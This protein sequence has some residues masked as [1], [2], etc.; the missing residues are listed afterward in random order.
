MNMENKTELL[1]MDI[2]DLE[3][4][5]L[6]QGQPRF[7]AKQI[8]GWIY[9]KEVSSFYEMSD[10]PKELRLRLDENATISIPRVLK[11]RVSKDNTRKFLLE[12][13]DKK[14]VETV[15][16][17]QGGDKNDRYS[18][19]IS[20]QV[21]CPVG[22]AFCATGASGF[23]RSL[24]A[25][26]MAGQVLGSRRELAKRLKIQDR[27]L[28]TN[29]VYMGMGEPMLNYDEVLKSVYMLNDHRGIDIGQRHITI[30]TAGEVKGIQ[31]LARE[32]I[33]ITLAVSLHACNNEL[34]SRLI[35]LNR[36]YPLELLM[37][38]VAE[39]IEISGRR[40]TFEYIMLDG[41]NMDLTDARAM[42]K[43]LKPL[44]ANVN[45]I[46]YNEVSGLEF[47]RPSPGQIR[48]FYNWLTE[49]GLNVTLREER[50]SDIEA[51]CGQL[52]AKRER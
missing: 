7:R 46:P 50:G 27:Q 1:G 37:E 11:Q 31:R 24:Q 42:I 45:L 14:K 8:Y 15:L 18:L 41:V 4:Y 20:T 38:S 52:A 51:A 13:K 49:G 39:Y 29:I 23:Q 12:M 35:P 33:Q 17:P 16:I 2:G 43:L 3:N 22:C 25:Y 10:I 40:V 9:R 30:S 19:C 26:E 47:K 48:Q 21:G 28:I 5:L 6:S 34:R 44:L 36:K 32:K